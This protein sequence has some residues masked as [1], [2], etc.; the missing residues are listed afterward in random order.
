MDCPTS[1]EEQALPNTFKL[2]RAAN[3]RLMLENMQ[4]SE[5]DWQA[6]AALLERRGFS[7]TGKTVNGADTVIYQDFVRDAITLAA[8]WDTW[9]GHYLL[10]GN[11]EGDR[12]L[13]ELHQQIAQAD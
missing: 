10:A 1:R 12:F 6:V 13:L 3:G 8:G 4:L 2:A 5:R 11:A 9:T 7:R